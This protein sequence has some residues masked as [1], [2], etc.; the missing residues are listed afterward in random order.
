MSRN[1]LF[2]FSKKKGAV[3]AVILKLPQSTR[4]CIYCGRSIT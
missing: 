4:F 1:Q 3:D 2:I